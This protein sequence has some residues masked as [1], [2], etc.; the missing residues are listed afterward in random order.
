MGGGRWATCRA[1]ELAQPVWPT[2]DTQANW[3]FGT[4]SKQTLHS[5]TPPPAGSPQGLA[6]RHYLVLLK[7]KSSSPKKKRHLPFPQN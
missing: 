4:F 1:D 5:P 2:Q 7:K 6:P 3:A